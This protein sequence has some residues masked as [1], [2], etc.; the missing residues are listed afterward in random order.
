MAESYKA[1]GLFIT[2][3]TL[4]EVLAIQAQAKKDVLAGRDITSY[5]DGGKNVGKTRNLPVGQILAECAEA[6]KA[7]DP[8]TY[9]LNRS[10]RRV[11]ATFN[12]TIEK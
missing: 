4:D 7:L 1:Q 2:G 11:H 10:T 5:G 8:T 6:L 3:F 12:T 9:G